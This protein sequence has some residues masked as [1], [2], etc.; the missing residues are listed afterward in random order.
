M[1]KNRF[2]LETLIKND[3]AQKKEL[4]KKLR[5]HNNITN[6]IKDIETNVDEQIAIN[7]V[8]M[9]TNTLTEYANSQDDEIVPVKTREPRSA[10]YNN[11]VNT[12]KH[13][14]IDA[15]VDFTDEDDHI[16]KTIHY[17]DVTLSL[18]YK[19]IL[20]FR[21]IEQYVKYFDNVCRVLFPFI[22][23]IIIGIIY[24]HKD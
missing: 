10:S 7:E 4:K 23:I 16:I 9:I 1:F 6:Q 13:K 8:E 22:F 15:Q 18:T 11:S 14:I 2:D 5:K 20:I 24:R 3:K 12:V 17:D 19:E 21:E